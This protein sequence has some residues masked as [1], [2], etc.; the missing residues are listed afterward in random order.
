MRSS[1]GT[2]STRSSSG[3]ASR[4]PSSP[5]SS[6]TRT[7]STCVP[8]SPS[9]PLSC[10]VSSQL[11]HLL[12]PTRAAGLLDR[13]R[14]RRLPRRLGRL[15]P[16]ARRP[17]ALFAQALLAAPAPPPA[18][19]RVRARRARLE[20]RSGRAATSQVGS[21]APGRP[22]PERVRRERAVLVRPVRRDDLV[23]RYVVAAQADLV[24]GQLRR[25]DRCGELPPPRGDELD[26]CQPRLPRDA[27]PVRARLWAPHR[28]RGAHARAAA[29]PARR[30]AQ[31]GACVEEGGREG[32]GAQ[33]AGS[34]SGG[35]SGGARAGRWAAQEDRHGHEQGDA[36]LGQERRVRVGHV[37]RD[38]RQ[39]VRVARRLG[40]LV[41]HG[42]RASSLLSS[43]SRLDSARF[44]ADAFLKH[45]SSS[46]RRSTTS[47][48]SATPGRT[49][50]SRTS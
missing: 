16:G 31:V 9:K 49:Q 17:H 20:R 12:T 1:G 40:A 5:A 43:S 41:R 42:A 48:S 6:P 26:V 14:A 19:R 13:R 10:A 7:T 3:R 24:A 27:A 4:A 18:G 30:D 33:R 28:E 36:A 50:P 46:S 22:P 29:E 8:L 39:G 2:P 47:S 35:W 21:P 11:R 23:A 34:R 25:P 44:T 37:D 38:A 15:R 45:R 32:A